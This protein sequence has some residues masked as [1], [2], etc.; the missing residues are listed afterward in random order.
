MLKIY[1]DNCCYGRPFDPPSNPTIVFESSA[2]M[3]IQTL[4]VNREVFLISSFVVYEEVSAILSDEKRNLII[5]F[6]ENTAVYIANDKV[7]EVLA[8]ADE[9]MKTGVKYMDA[10]HVACAV[11]AG[12]DYFISTDKRLLK[13]K[14]DKIN[15]IN[16]IDFIRM[17][18]ERNDA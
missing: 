7:G 3:L 18:E 11:I 13:H 1:L 4:V 10:S 12:C 17:W 6:L 2:K 16:P 9:I 14:S 5:D 15:I 8:L